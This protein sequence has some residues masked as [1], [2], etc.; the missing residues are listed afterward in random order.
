MLAAGFFFLL[1]HSSGD[2][3]CRL[4]CAPVPVCLLCRLGLPGVIGGNGLFPGPSVG[5]ES[6]LATHSEQVFREE[7]RRGMRHFKSHIDRATL[8]V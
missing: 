4:L 8:Q 3:D 2:D 6:W 7:E 1:G 5:A